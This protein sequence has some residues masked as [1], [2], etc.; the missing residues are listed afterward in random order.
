MTIRAFKNWQKLEILFFFMYHRQDV[1]N[2]RIVNNEIIFFL[3]TEADA[4]E[5]R[6]MD[7]ITS[8]WRA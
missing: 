2:Y 4:M 3:D 5:A 6:R 7:V 1:T 8:N